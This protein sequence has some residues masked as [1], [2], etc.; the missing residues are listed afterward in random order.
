MLEEEQ[1][2]VSTNLLTTNTSLVVM[3]L[4]TTNQASLSPP[5]LALWPSVRVNQPGWTETNG[6]ITIEWA[7]STPR[8]VLSVISLEHKFK[9]IIMR[10]EWTGKQES[11]SCECFSLNCPHI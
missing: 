4:S 7:G 1:K 6:K 11:V 3:S 10:K 9:M 5:I 8:T 2:D